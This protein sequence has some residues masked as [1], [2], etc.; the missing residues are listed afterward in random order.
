MLL[1]P[2]DLTLFADA[3]GDRNPLHV[4]AEYARRTPFGQPVA[5]GV[6]TAVAALDEVPGPPGEISGVD[7]EFTRP[8]HA[9][10]PYSTNISH[11]PDGRTKVTVA[12]GAETCL[13]VR[14][15]H[16]PGGTAVA[17]P[18]RPRSHPRSFAPEEFARGL[19]VS[20]QYGPGSELDALVARWPGAAR[21]LGRTALTGL[22]WCSFVAGMELPG[23]DCLLNTISLRLRPAGGR[24]ALRYRAEVRDFDPRFGLLT[25]EAELDD[26]AAVVAEATLETMV[27][28]PV[29]GPDSDRLVALLPCSD[30]LYGCTAAIAGGSRGLG[31]ALV[32]ALASQGARVLV[33]HR[34]GDLS[35]LAVKGAELGGEVVSCPGD[36]ADPAWA[37][38]V[39]RLAGDELDLLVCSAAPPIR[40]LRL[41]SASL[42]RV[43]NFVADAFALASAPL[44]GLLPS[45][46]K[47]S[48]RCLVVSSSA[49]A[50]PPAD[51]PHY[52]AAKHAVEGLTQWA[53]AQHPECE[54][55]VSRPGMLLTEQMNTPGTR[56]IAQAVEP[57]AAAMADRLADSAPAKSRPELI[58]H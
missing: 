51:W 29:P 21:L 46:A 58:E 57:V 9:G 45:L 16:G 38:Q 37:D 32:L 30:R 13:T 22:L 47:T 31:A 50:E 34:S 27:R 42:P 11:D 35:E 7:L 28:R 10:F 14:L 17:A 20:G 26:G 39:R 43:Q 12:E 2:A 3:S 55:F 6:L 18:R 53:A 54:F 36:A 48:G 44:A 8:T 15:T 5:H 33:G 40:P 4:D 49:V 41:D 24:P 52:V 19:A 25:V 23:R 56:E 1:A